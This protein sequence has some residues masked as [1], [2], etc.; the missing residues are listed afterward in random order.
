MAQR[1][2]TKGGRRSFLSRLTP[3]TALTVLL[4]VTTVDVFILPLL[5]LRSRWID[6][7]VTLQILSALGVVMR[8]SRLRVIASAA[9]VAT[10]LS[11]WTPELGSATAQAMWHLTSRLVLIMIVAGVISRRAFEPGTITIH[12]IAGAV[13]LYMLFGVMFSLGYHLIW[14]HDPGAFSGLV[15]PTATQPDVQAEFSYFS[16]MTLTTVG[17]GDIHPVSEQARRMATLEALLGQL[18]PAITLARL[19]SLK[20]MHEPA[21]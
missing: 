6:A 14:L 9:A 19:V 8:V 4:V 16:F 2:S 15:T 20:V 11:L 3:H 17:Y 13:L 18:Y 12:R 5:P 21:S 7:M 1:T 10:A